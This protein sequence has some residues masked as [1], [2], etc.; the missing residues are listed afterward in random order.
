MIGIFDSGEGGRNALYEIRKRAPWI[1]VCYLADRKNA[2]YGTKSRDEL[3]ELVSR[4]VE[5][6]LS[7]GASKILMAC[8]TASTVH[9]LLEK[10][11]RSASIPII[12]PTAH[13]AARLT[14]NGKVGVIATAATV[15]SGAFR[16][17]LLSCGIKEVVEVKAQPL[18]EIVEKSLLYGNGGQDSARMIRDILRPIKEFGADALILGCTHF[19]RLKN[20][21]SGA[22]P[23]VEM[24]SSSRAGA[25]EVLKNAPC[26]GRGQTVYME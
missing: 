5:R 7:F 14:K 9:P 17:E 11:L 15:N 23:G 8:C 6:L 3:V 13:E 1:D 2:P 20:I 12:S 16:E 24:I 4:D 18:V 22:L 25:I 10:R 26:R 21:I 19:C